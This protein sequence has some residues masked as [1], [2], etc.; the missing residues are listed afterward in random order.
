M[1]ILMIFCYISNPSDWQL[2][3]NMRVVNSIS[4]GNRYVY[5]AGEGI[6]RYDKLFQKYEVPVSRDALPLDIK[7]IQQDI[8]TGEVWFTTPKGL[9]KY[10]PTFENYKFTDM[11]NIAGVCSLGVSDRYI[12]LRNGNKYIKVD[13]FSGSSDVTDSIPQQ[14]SWEPKNS[15]QEYSWLA[16]WYTMDKSLNRYPVVC[17]EVDEQFL[18]VGTSGDGIYKYSAVGFNLLEH[19]L[20][21][22]PSGRI[23]SL[24]KTGD[25]LWFG[26]LSEIGNYI[27]G[28]GAFSSYLFSNTINLLNSEITAM[29]FNNKYMWFG[30]RTGISQ[31]NKSKNIWY[32][33]IEA[34][35]VLSLEVKGDEL[36]IGTNSGLL[37]L[38]NGYMGTVIKNICVNDVAVCSTVVW[39]ATDRGVFSLNDTGWVQ[40][41]DP[42]KI[43]SHGV[44]RLLFDEYGKWFGAK[45]GL[46]LYKK[47]NSW[48]RFNY[49]TVLPGERIMCL[50]ADENTLYVGTDRGVGAFNKNS[51][52][53][54]RYDEKNSYMNGVVYS[55]V[56]D[57]GYVYFG[58]DNGIV[59]LKK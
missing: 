49:P 14:V 48:D 42:D 15:P 28:Q 50:G 32:N 44:Y 26:A 13:K 16:P 3:R 46:L 7:L 30:S 58:T 36:W 21:G 55:V 57:K 38:T 29:A 25:T 6:L 9:G 54:N 43:M 40:F 22:F 10:T 39:I 12:Y 45:Q 31:F 23:M 8:Y 59:K 53:W 17:S 51:K 56:V 1:I 37:K 41:N 47:D 5:F 11:N 33:F 34:S 19:C 4:A 27:I 35:D 20:Y 24:F 18:W 2:L 52:S